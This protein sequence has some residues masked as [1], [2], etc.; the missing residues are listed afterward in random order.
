MKSIVVFWGGE[1]L[2]CLMTQWFWAQDL[3]LLAFTAQKFPS[4]KIS[5]LK[6]FCLHFT[7]KDTSFTAQK[8]SGGSLISVLSTGIV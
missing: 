4:D 3:P 2:Y 8:I 7:S 1:V 6:S 5:Q